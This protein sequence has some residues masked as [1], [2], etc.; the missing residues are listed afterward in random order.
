MKATKNLKQQKPFKYSRLNEYR[1]TASH[2]CT[3]FRAI[4][5]R[6]KKDDACEIERLMEKNHLQAAH[7]KE[8]HCS[9]EKN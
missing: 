8:T 9:N 3:F 7:R 4:A 6:A 5:R 1:K 2:Q